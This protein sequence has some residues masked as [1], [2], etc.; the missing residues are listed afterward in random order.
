MERQQSAIWFHGPTGDRPIS[1]E[2]Y[3]YRP[4]MS[5]DGSKVFYLGCRVATIFRSFLAPHVGW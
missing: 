3:S 1:V 2:G 5:P 4:V